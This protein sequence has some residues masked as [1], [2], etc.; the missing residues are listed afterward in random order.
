VAEFGFSFRNLPELIIEGRMT[1]KGRI[2]YYFKAFGSVSIV[3]V[4]VTLKVGDLEERLNAIAQVIAESDG[5]S[6]Y[7]CS[8]GYVILGIHSV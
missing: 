4:E 1:T 7:L 5:E 8:M 6:F 3:F 2:E